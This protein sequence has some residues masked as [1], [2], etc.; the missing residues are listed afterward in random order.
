MKTRYQYK[1]GCICKLKLVSS[2]ASFRWKVWT[3]DGQ[4]QLWAGRPTVVDIHARQ[5]AVA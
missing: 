4:L 3:H 1:C 5:K 2:G